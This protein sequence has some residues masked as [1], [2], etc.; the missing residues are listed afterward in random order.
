LS[1][2]GARGVGWSAAILSA[3]LVSGV[4]LLSV[5]LNRL[6]KFLSLASGMASGPWIEVLLVLVAVLLRGFLHTGLFIVA[7]DAMHGVLRPACPEANARWGRLALT[8]YAGL[9][10]NSCRAKHELH[11]RFSGGSGDPDVHGAERPGLKAALRWFLHFLGGYLSWE[12]MARLL[13]GWGALGLLSLAVTPTAGLNLLLFCILPLLLSSAQL[14]VFGTYLPHRAT[15]PDS[16]SRKPRSLDLPVWLSLLTCYHF[17]YHWEH[18]QYPW[19]AWHELPGSRC[20]SSS[21]KV[22]VREN[23]AWLNGA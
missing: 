21:D 11:H 17:G 22:S 19:L 1:T 2:G 16:G 3:W 6:G 23:A 9:A 18:H 4:G 12:Q 8:L 15:D 20:L 10:Y 14:F 5:D 7:H 13:G